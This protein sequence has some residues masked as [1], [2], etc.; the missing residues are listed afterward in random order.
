MKRI[1][2]TVSGSLFWES[3]Y[4]TG[5]YG[6]GSRVPSWFVDLRN[7]GKIK[8]NCM[9]HATINLRSDGFLF[10]IQ[11][12]YDAYTE[13]FGSVE[14]CQAALEKMFKRE[15]YSNKE[16]SFWE[17]F[18][19]MP[20]PDCYDFNNLWRVAATAQRTGRFFYSAKRITAKNYIL[21]DIEIA[22][23]LYLES[24]DQSTDEYEIRY[25]ERVSRMAQEKEYREDNAKKYSHTVEFEFNGAEKSKYSAYFETLC[26]HENASLR[27]IKN[28]Y[29]DLAKKYHPDLNP[30]NKDNANKF[31]EIANAYHEITKPFKK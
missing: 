26:I 3:G 11:K 5:T 24:F 12:T 6:G 8:V 9:S 28:A 22:P 18:E 4:P 16:G 14:K 31:Q 1:V 25:R 17:C 27:E 21:D 7:Q 2:K 23:W 10:H 19:Y 30:V 15:N 29:W 13:A 20:S